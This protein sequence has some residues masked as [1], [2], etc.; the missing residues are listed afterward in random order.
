MLIGLGK[1]CFI[2]VNLAL[3]QKFLQSNHSSLQ[4][5]TAPINGFIESLIGKLQQLSRH[6]SV[7]KN[8]QN[9]L[10]L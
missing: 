10:K 2:D 6:N 8:K 9:S 3:I 7:A 5:L 1:R 4:T